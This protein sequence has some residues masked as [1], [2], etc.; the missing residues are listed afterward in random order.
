[1]HSLGLSGTGSQEPCWQDFYSVAAV[2]QR[3]AAAAVEVHPDGAVVLG[4]G[5]HEAAGLKARGEPDPDAV[6]L[7]QLLPVRVRRHPA[8]RLFVRVVVRYLAMISPLSVK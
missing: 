1:M 7:A 4:D 5:V 6:A 3:A 2:Q 8:Q